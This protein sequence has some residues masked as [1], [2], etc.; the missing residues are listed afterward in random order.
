MLSRPEEDVATMANAA[1]RERETTG[2]AQAAPLM[3]A[4]TAPLRHRNATS[5]SMARTRPVR[6][7]PVVREQAP[8]AVLPGFDLAGTV[9]VRRGPVAAIV[10]GARGRLFVTTP[11]RDS[12]AVLDVAQQ[13]VIGAVKDIYEPFG[14]VAAGGRA[15]VSAVLA[16][17]DELAVIDTAT[18]A[19]QA[20]YP[21]AGNVR[22]LVAAPDGSRVYLTRTDDDGADVAVFDTATA[23]FTSIALGGPGTVADA[24]AISPDG[25]RLYVG[26]VDN[27]ASDVLVVDIAAARVVNTI[28]I[29]APIR[30]IAVHPSG[31]SVYVLSSDPVAGGTVHMVDAR[32]TRVAGTVALGGLPTSMSI[33]R[34]GGRLYVTDIERVSVVCTGTASVV[35][36]LDVAAEPSVAVESADGATLYVADYEGRVTSF[37]IATAGVTNGA[38]AAPPAIR[39]HPAAV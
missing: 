33:S 30:A 4:P 6:R 8:V 1:V 21:V 25:A 10:E 18:G 28:Q 17:N 27:F 15:Y 35:E 31:A 14:A 2:T 36:A 26:V 24:V 39:R 29:D 20:T 32:S 37:R 12:V 16:A 5:P 13:S 23:E 9:D 7:L 22:A 11:G 34:D 19:L 38:A 3:S